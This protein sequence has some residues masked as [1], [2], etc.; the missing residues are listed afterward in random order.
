M[1]FD[2][3]TLSSPIK[4][5]T[6]KTMTLLGDVY[7]IPECKMREGHD[8]QLKCHRQIIDRLSLR[9]IIQHIVLDLEF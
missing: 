8:I 5:K 2:A 3:I 9:Q 6:N 1:S 7:E 4:K